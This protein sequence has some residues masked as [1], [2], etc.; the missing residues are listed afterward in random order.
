[1]GKILAPVQLSL[2]YPLWH[3]DDHNVLSY[4]PLALL[5]VTVAVAFRFRR[6][7]GK[8]A[9]GT[10]GYILVALLP[11]LGFVDISFMRCSRVADHWL[12]LPMV[13]LL[14][15]ACSGV[16]MLLSR[17]KA[18]ARPVA[19]GLGC[20]VLALLLAQTFTRSAVFASQE[21]LWADTIDHNPD[22]WLAW[23]N[24]GVIKGDQG[25]PA[26]AMADYERTLALNPRNAEALN[27][28][29]QIEF[30][31]GRYER[32]RELYLQSLA[33]N[34]GN[35]MCHNSMGTLFIRMGEK[36][37]A[38]K[39]FQKAVELDPC[40]TTA[41]NNL[42]LMY[43]LEGRYDL[44]Y[45][46]YKTSVE[47]DPSD[48]DSQLKLAGA[49]CMTGRLEES[50]EICRSLL[51]KGCASPPLYTQLGLVLICQ[52]QPDAAA[53]MFRQALVMDGS[54]RPAL[55]GLRQALGPHS[56]RPVAQP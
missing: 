8:Y 19:V 54:Y 32:A 47:M 37:K 25:R 12:Y 13:G 55:N 45:Q 23:Y 16:W 18:S 56:N 48:A 46:C 50:A 33:I 2:I 14:A 10:V 30:S 11:V 53:G 9:L 49:S 41:R 1:V 21:T 29:G 35:P 31:Q 3:V 4:V 52:G 22:C 40:F 38:R 51:N 5:A 24:L 42:G 44:C 34:P 6:T 27:N 26:E 17:W 7:W 43:Q 36:E 20:I 15:A 28:M 39:E